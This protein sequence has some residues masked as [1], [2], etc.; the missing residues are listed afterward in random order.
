[1]K[2][3]SC[4]LMQGVEWIGQG[5]PAPEAWHRLESSITRQACHSGAAAEASF[6]GEEDQDAAESAARRCIREHLGDAFALPSCGAMPG[7]IQ[8]RVRAGG[9]GSGK[10]G[11]GYARKVLSRSPAC[12]MHGCMRF[13]SRSSGFA[14][15]FHGSA[16][17]NVSHFHPHCRPAAVRPSL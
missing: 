4:A 8:W 12:C 1:M 3:Y 16:A 14:P 13:I 9:G 7:T 11:V 17:G 6:I 15:Y 5:P 10:K 2:S